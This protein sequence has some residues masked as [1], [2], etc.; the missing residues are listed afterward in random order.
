[1]IISAQMVGNKHCYT[2]LKQGAFL[3]PPLGGKSY[4]GG[5]CRGGEIG[6]ITKGGA[7]AR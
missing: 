4:S 6:G 1:M 2:P 3:D 7:A 5:R